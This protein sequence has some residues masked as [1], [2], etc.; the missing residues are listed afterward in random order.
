MVTE[1]APRKTA[2]RLLAVVQAA[3]DDRN[4]CR[5]TAKALIGQMGGRQ[6][7][8]AERGEQRQ[9]RGPRSRWISDCSLLERQQRS[10]RHHGPPGPSRALLSLADERLSARDE[11]RRTRGHEGRCNL[12][13]TPGASARRGVREKE[14]H[15]VGAER[16]CLSAN[17]LRAVQDASLVFG[18]GRVELWRSA[19]GRV[20][21]LRGNSANASRFRAAD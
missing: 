18:L 15:V 6:T 11:R 9:A 16:P 5:R 1:K 8:A 13:D 4:C 14:G 12:R 10:P 19:V 17:A 21:S 20:R 2:A 7:R 3:D